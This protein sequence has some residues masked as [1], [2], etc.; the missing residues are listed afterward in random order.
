[1]EEENAYI[2]LNE[3]DLTK[4]HTHLELS[5]I[6]MLGITTSLIPYSNFDSSSRLIRGSKI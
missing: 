2:A 6:T 4:D 5:P 3:E 1:M